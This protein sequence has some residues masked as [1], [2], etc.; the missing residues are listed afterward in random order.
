MKYPV[1]QQSTP[2]KVFLWTQ[3]VF[4]M[5]RF[6]TWVLPV[7]DSC[8]ARLCLSPLASPPSLCPPLFQVS[9]LLCPG[10][11][12]NGCYRV[13]QNK[14]AKKKKW[15]QVVLRGNHTASTCFPSC[16]LTQGHQPRTDFWEKRELA[17]SFLDELLIPGNILSL[18]FSELFAGGI[19]LRR[20]SSIVPETNIK[21]QINDFKILSSLFWYILSFAV[22]LKRLKQQ[23]HSTKIIIQGEFVIVPYLNG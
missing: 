2:P 13:T 17:A 10:Q 5:L 22:S 19:R 3:Y 7:W 20:S 4:I 23:G 9:S 11:W 21:I 1:I 14:N 18:H 8:L 16:S 15:M 6:R 12:K